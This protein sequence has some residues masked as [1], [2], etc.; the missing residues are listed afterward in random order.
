[1]P[2]MRAS[3]R[4]NWWKTTF[5]FCQVTPAVFPGAFLSLPLFSLFQFA[6]I[7]NFFLKKILFSLA[8]SKKE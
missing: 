5:S 3:I 4:I 8:I 1:M 7:A 6:I 2:A